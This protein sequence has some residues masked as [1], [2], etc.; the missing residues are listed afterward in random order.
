MEK[1]C[2]NCVERIEL[3]EMKGEPMPNL[4]LSKTVNAPVEKTFQLFSDFPNA[5]ARIDGITN[6]EMLTDGPVG[7]GTR[8]KETRVMF[9]RE[10]TEEMEVTQFEPNRLYTVA[11]NS[12]GARMES[13]FKFQPV[14]NQTRVEMNLETKAQSVFAKLFSPLAFL[15]VGSIKKAMQSDIDQIAKLCEHH[16]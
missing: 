10:A 14:G 2:F 6:V 1:F 7:V 8:F 12:C 13:T 11:A 15:L 9:G 5:A 16:D 4:R 3:I